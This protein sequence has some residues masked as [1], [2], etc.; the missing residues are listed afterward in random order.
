MLRF[1]CVLFENEALT[2]QA[3]SDT[4]ENRK[5]LKSISLELTGCYY[6]VFVVDLGD[7]F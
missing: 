3:S 1:R 7:N 5:I 2:V 4:K 6:W